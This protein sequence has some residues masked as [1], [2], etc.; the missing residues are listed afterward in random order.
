MY[1]QIYMII[2]LKSILDIWCAQNWT[3]LNYDKELECIDI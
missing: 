1:N 2:N 3:K